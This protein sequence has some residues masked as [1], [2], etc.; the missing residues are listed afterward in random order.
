[1][2]KTLNEIKSKLELNEIDKLI[3]FF[4]FIS[5]GIKCQLCYLKAS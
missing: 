1:M 4:L 3:S 2:E 5:L